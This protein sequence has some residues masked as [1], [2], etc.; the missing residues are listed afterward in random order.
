MCR[1]SSSEGVYMEWLRKLAR[2][3][4]ASLVVVESIY[5]QQLSAAEAIQQHI[6]ALPAKA[7]VVLHLSDGHTMRGRIVSRNNQDFALKLDNG[8]TPQTIAY[9]QVTAVEEVSGQHS[10][11]KWIVIGVVAVAAVV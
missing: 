7:H 2:C 1:S 8:G 10:K 5:A 4:L 6:A 11:M 3:V 9:Q